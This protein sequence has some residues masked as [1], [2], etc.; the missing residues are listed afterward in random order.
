MQKKDEKYKRKLFLPINTVL[1]PVYRDRY[2]A[3]N[4]DR[5]S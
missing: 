2:S 1:I 4:I 5:R 3:K